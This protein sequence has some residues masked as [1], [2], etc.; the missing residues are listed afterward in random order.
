MSSGYHGAA[1]RYPYPE[2]QA[3]QEYTDQQSTRRDEMNGETASERKRQKRN[4]P[5]LSCHECVERKTKV[6]E[7]TR[8]VHADKSTNF[9]H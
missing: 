2:N 1:P 9:I 8:Q 4:K 7:I 5:T 6:S 3:K